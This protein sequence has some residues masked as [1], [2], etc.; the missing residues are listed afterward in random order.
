[1]EIQYGA[2]QEAKPGSSAEQCEDVF[3]YSDASSLVAVCDGAGTAFESRLWA[4]LLARGFVEHPPLGATHDELLE[5]VDVIARQWSQSIPWKALD[6]FQELKAR[7]GSAA[8]L[9]GLQLTPPPQQAAAGTWR[10]LAMGDSCL[11][12]V[13]HGRLVEALPV[14]NSADFSVHTSLLSTERGSNLR[15]IGKVVTE[16]GTWQE[17]DS[18]FLL[19]DAIAQWFLRESEQG[20]TP[21]GT[22]TSLDEPRF[23]AFVQDAQARRLMRQDDVTAFMIGLGVPLETRTTPAP[24]P[25]SPRRARAP[26]VASAAS[27]DLSSDGGSSQPAGPPASGLLKSPPERPRR[28]PQLPGPPGPGRTARSRRRRAGLIAAAGLV[29]A[30]VI[31]IVVTALVGGSSPP[32]PQP[33]L[34]QVQPAARGF[35]ELLTTYPGGGA[36]AFRAYESALGND[37]AGRNAAMVTRLVGLGQPP[38]S[39]FT[40]QGKG[41]SVAE[42]RASPSQA[43]LYVLVEQAINAPYTY[44]QSYQC[45]TT[46]EPAPHTCHAT[47]TGT[48]KSSRLLLID[49]TM[50]R[51]GQ[52]WL[53]GDAQIWLVSA[54]SGA[55]VVQGGTQ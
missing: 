37:V 10:C 33:P 49:L 20:A 19:T 35:A 42:V 34:P 26:E 55:L 27:A 51:Q 52:R 3:A 16:T 15:S 11:F 40:S 36:T 47:R 17:G 24:V 29:L 50:V 23:Q 7:S 12:Q 54:A 39:L 41:V 22:L 44:V 53:A 46:N 25:V 1:M 32:A 30:A 48:K 43:E 13:S 18:F 31:A 38:P 45:V 14:R 4:G 6:V 5:W 9:I 8:T 28:P 2:L 21:W